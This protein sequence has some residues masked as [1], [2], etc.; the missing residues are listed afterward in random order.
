[1]K[2]FVP[3]LVKPAVALAGLAAAGYFYSLSKGRGYEEGLK[4]VTIAFGVVLAMAL[5]LHTWD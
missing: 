5:S 3:Y 2:W 4:W 1:M